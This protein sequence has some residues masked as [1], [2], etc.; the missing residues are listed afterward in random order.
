MD[1]PHARHAEGLADQ[2]EELVEA[3]WLRSAHLV[4]LSHGDGK[5]EGA[6]E[7]FRD[8]LYGNGLEPILPVAQY[9][10]GG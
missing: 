9:G 2:V 10:Y 8:L 5:T 3:I 1:L 6:R 7:A 4:G